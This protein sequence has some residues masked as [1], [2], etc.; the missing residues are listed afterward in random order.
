MFL[1]TEANHGAT[2]LVI[3]SN[4]NNILNAVDNLR[5]KEQFVDRLLS[6]LQRT[7]KVIA[8]VY[9]TSGKEEEKRAIDQHL[10]QYVQS[11]PDVKRLISYNEV[12]PSGEQLYHFIGHYRSDLTS[13]RFISKG[14]KNGDTAE[15]RVSQQGKVV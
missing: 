11:H 14:E 5:A 3:H 13:W 6:R 15:F 7:Y 8:R 2:P 9:W 12:S 4:R 10:D 1:A